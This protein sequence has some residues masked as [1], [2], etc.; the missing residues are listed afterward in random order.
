M[1]KVALITNQSIMFKIDDKHQPVMLNMTLIINHVSDAKQAGYSEQF[2][3][4]C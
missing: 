4:H 3:H 2:K 1:L